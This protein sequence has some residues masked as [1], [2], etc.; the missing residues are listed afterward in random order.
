[1]KY[2]SVLSLITAFA[3]FSTSASA[4]IKLQ[5]EEGVGCNKKLCIEAIEEAVKMRGGLCEIININDLTITDACNN[6]TN[7]VTQTS[8]TEKCNN[9]NLK[10]ID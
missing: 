3:V 5:L 7:F 6:K 8:N 2:L 4:F 1:M 10:Q 9:C